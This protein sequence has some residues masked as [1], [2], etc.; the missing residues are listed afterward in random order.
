[1][2]GGGGTS[3]GGPYTLSGITGQPDAGVVS[4]VTYTVTG[5]FWA[6]AAP[7]LYAVYLPLVLRNY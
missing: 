6:D 4:N 3:S 1:V 5:G 7:P 2:D